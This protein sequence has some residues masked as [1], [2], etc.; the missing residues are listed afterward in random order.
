MAMVG[1]DPD[2]VVAEELDSLVD[3]ARLDS[4]SPPKA[5]KLFETMMRA[6][7][8]RAALNA[9]PEGRVAEVVP[10]ATGPPAGHVEVATIETVPAVPAASG[11]AVETDVDIVQVVS[12]RVVPEPATSTLD[13]LGRV[14]LKSVRY[15]VAR[16]EATMKV[17]L[18]PPSLGEV[19]FEVTS[20]DRVLSIRLVSANPAVREILEGQLAG[21]RESLVRDGHQV[22]EISV[23]ADAASGHSAAHEHR[24]SAAFNGAPQTSTSAPDGHDLSAD[25]RDLNEE[26]TPTHAGTLNLFI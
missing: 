23:T 26:R 24:R 5:V 12:E 18:E 22:T 1:L 7:A 15:L 10:T 8:S 20:V 25:P 13:N 19:R 14:T 17:R 21:L 4:L 3:P 9:T 6:A 2:A 11:L 16:G